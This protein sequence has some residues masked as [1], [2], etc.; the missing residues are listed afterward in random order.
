MV[1]VEVEVERERVIVVEVEIN[2]QTCGC[3][4]WLTRACRH[5]FGL[6]AVSKEESN[7]FLVFGCSAALHMKLQEDRTQLPKQD[8]SKDA[9]KPS[10]C[11]N[12]S[13]TGVVTMLLPKEDTL[14]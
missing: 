6:P 13:K 11:S 2:R 10:I 8:K 3:G 1:V 14:T 4:V 12:T 9:G 5:Q 7:N